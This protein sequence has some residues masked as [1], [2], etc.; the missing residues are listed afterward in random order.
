MP[1]AIEAL[2]Q[3]GVSAASLLY[4]HQRGDWRDLDEEDKKENSVDLS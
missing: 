4:R 1:G 3:S 2:Q